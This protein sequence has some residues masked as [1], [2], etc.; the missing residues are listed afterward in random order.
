MRHGLR[1][2]LVVALDIAAFAAVFLGFYAA[3]LPLLPTSDEGRI[4][5]GV[6]A[7][8][9]AATAGGAWGAWWA[10]RTAAAP[11]APPEPG[12]RWEL[13]HATVTVHRDPSDPPA[14]PRPVRT[15][16]LPREPAGFQPREDLLAELAAATERH[17]LTVVHAVT[18][19]RGVG[20]TQLA[21]A[22][23]RRRIEEGWPVVAWITAENSGQLTRGLADL[24]DQLEVREA[25]DD[26]PTAARAALTWIG[27]NPDPCLLV[28]DNA[29]DPDEVLGRLPT[30]GRAQVVVT[31]TDR[32]FE[33]LA[34]A[35]VD[36]TVFSREEALDFLRHR[37]GL[38]HDPHTDA[39]ALEV[40][41][42]LGRLPLALA[43]AAHVIRVRGSGYQGYLHRLRTY[44]LED[45]LERVP[46][47]RYPH[48][49][50]EAVLMAVEEAE[51]G[52]HGRLVRVLLEALSV[53]S[54]A[55]VP[56]DVL[57]GVLRQA[58]F[59]DTADP[60]A[61]L[62]ALTQVSL[63][64]DAGADAVA[65]HRLVR[66]VVR[67]RSGDAIRPV[68]G[69]VAGH[70]TEV[71]I[72]DSQAWERREFGGQLVDQ[73]DTLWGVVRE[74]LAAYDEEQ[75]EALVR[76]RYWAAYDHLGEVG[77]LARAV[78]WAA[79][80]RRD[81]ERVLS[82]DSGAFLIALELEGDMH[83]WVGHT[84][85]A[86]ADRERLLELVERRRGPEHTDT[87]EARRSL[88]ATL[89]NTGR[90]EL[91]VPLYEA[92]ERDV[93]RIHGADH[94]QTRGAQRRLANAYA[95][96]GRLGEAVRIVDLLRGDLLQASGT[97][98]SD[99]DSLP[100][101]AD[102]YG[103]VGRQ[104]EGAALLRR[105]L[106]EC[107]ATHGP[108]ASDTIWARNDL[109]LQ[110]MDAALYTE[111]LAAAERA[112]ADAERV[113]GD[114]A[115]DTTEIRD[116]LATCLQS[117]DRDSEAMALF[118]R[119]VA[120]R[121]AVHGPEHPRVLAARARLVWS[122]DESR[123]PREAYTEQRELIA[124]Y[125][126]LLGDDH[127]STFGVRRFHIHL[128]TRHGRI[129]E[130]VEFAREVLADHQRVH[131]STHPRTFDVCLAL[132]DALTASSRY[133][134]A[135]ALLRQTLLDTTRAL[136]PGHGH[137]FSARSRL[138]SVL[139]EVGAFDEARA[140]REDAVT[141]SVRLYGDQHMEVVYAR[142]DLADAL[143]ACSQHEEALALH[144]EVVEDIA[145]L[146]GA[147]HPSTTLARRWL[148]DACGKAERH[149]ERCELAHRAALDTER[150]HGADSLVTLAARDEYMWALRAVGRRREARRGRRQ[151]LADY[152]RL[153][154]VGHPFS[155]R[156]LDDVADGHREVQRRLKALR[157]RRRV[158]AAHEA[159]ADPWHG[160]SV[161]ARRRLGTAYASVGLVHRGVAVQRRLLDDLTERYG[162]D[163]GAVLT[164]HHWLAHALLRT[165]RRGAASAVAQACRRA[166]ERV[167]GPDHP[168]TLD[169]RLRVAMVNRLTGRPR[170]ALREYAA[171]AADRARVHGADHPLAWYAR[172]HHAKA[173]LW[174]LHPHRSVAAF[175]TVLQDGVRLFGPDSPQV[176]NLA[177][178]R[179][180]LLCLATGHWRRLRAARALR[181]RPAVLPGE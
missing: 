62:G 66:R 44:P 76:L 173:L 138:A 22:Y 148:A 125:T 7:A 5:L 120:E 115:E 31:A 20:K 26:E 43:Q 60:E 53:L 36:V 147:D 83:A 85:Q 2:A 156:C 97:T 29:T 89:Q 104:E 151:L 160:E 134:E 65:V 178:W 157:I 88:A 23:A 64:T 18:G 25:G 100:S 176:R 163:H 136:G 133:P 21:A 158:L 162:P 180:P 81:C 139:T 90:Y 19:A 129:Q 40:A 41:E 102:A 72:P 87:L 48:R 70:L 128:C 135:V 51:R 175:D 47:E 75:Q 172:V 168:R 141:E 118:R 108:D 61:A 106:A 35:R 54:P 42:E 28:L 12:V 57:T 78:D 17:S 14:A 8:T 179:Y 181:P 1:W 69:A 49:V 150:T 59:D 73:I 79:E 153:L 131:G 50:A 113:F 159:R 114:E 99:L 16:D 111:G 101:L 27:R 177:A 92:L 46:G 112:L 95:T 122:L 94:E 123:R 74:D 15:G 84:R 127:P 170:V 6:A 167:H 144:R 146:R 119:V 10:P 103:S 96:A 154:G 71:L 58:G 164:Q 3:D 63:A 33:N 174:A 149:G 117:V 124:D 32:A 39:E 130:G 34:G 121:I 45:V 109:A 13:P 152:V 82:E 56:R 55:G 145:R 169:A 4:A 155:I 142:S 140:L 98:T 132:A 52:E 30:A 38:P 137:T 107:E 77:A 105:Y 9:V 37:T 126:R 143:T 80:T 11:A 166:C 24:A 116:T 110:C 91:A 86:I 67:E 68:V 161:G 171:L 165:G 93:R